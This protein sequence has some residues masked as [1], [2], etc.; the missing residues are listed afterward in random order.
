MSER[1]GVWC[2]KGIGTSKN[3]KLAIEWFFKSAISGYASAYKNIVLIYDQEDV[4]VTGKPAEKVFEYFENAVQNGDAEDKYFFALCYY[5]GI[6]V[7]INDELAFYW[8]NESAKQGD[9]EAMNALGGFYLEGIGV[10]ASIEKAILSY[11]KAAK[12][13]NKSS[14]KHLI[15]LF[16]KKEGKKFFGDEQFDIFVKAAQI[17]IKTIPCVTR[18]WLNEGIGHYEDSDGVQYSADGKRLLRTNMYF[19]PNNN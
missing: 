6:G 8:L 15:K 17:G 2:Y 5:Y 14:M 19:K 11:T 1:L 9:D 4:D 16:D 10:E 12:L 13:G 7:D 3:H 18:S